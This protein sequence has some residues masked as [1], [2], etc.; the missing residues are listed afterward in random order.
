MDMQKSSQTGKKILTTLFLSYWKKINRP[1]SSSGNPNRFPV[2]FFFF[3]LLKFT[4][5]AGLILKTPWAMNG[6]SL[7]GYL[8]MPLSEKK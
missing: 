3:F 8:N 4:L 2:I 1:T 6:F 7:L 5:H